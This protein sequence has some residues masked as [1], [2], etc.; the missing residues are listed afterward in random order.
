M[1]NR[2]KRSFWGG[3]FLLFG[4]FSHTGMAADH[5]DGPLVRG[6]PA[7]DITDVYAWMEDSSTMNLI[8]NVFPSAGA[9]AQFSN[10]VQYVFHVNSSASYGAAQ[11]EKIIL[12][13]FEVNQNVTCEVGGEKILSDVNA[14]SV[15]GVS[16]EEGTFKLFTGLRNDP[17]FFDSN[18]FNLVRTT[19][20]DAASSLDFDEAGCPTLDNVTRSTL[21]DTLTGNAA[22]ISGAN[23][24]GSN[25]FAP[26]NVL[27]IV[28]QVDTALLGEG[29]VY[30]V[31]AST[32]RR[33][34]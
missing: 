13:T 23:V 8:L 26:L 21:V 34:S 1:I 30:S 22:T 9:D 25:S 2:L 19:V 15:S 31:W 5:L 33:Q 20:R 12:C 14:S 24:P 6:E 27:S 11:S 17:F 28:I 29:P 10:A 18:N 16:N 32:N 7:A 3:C 4:I